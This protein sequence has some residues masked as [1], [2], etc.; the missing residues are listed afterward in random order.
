[1]T[2]ILSDYDLHLLAEGTH[3]RSFEVLGAHPRHNEEEEEAGTSF[4]VWAP[5]ARAVS[6]IGDFNGWDVDANP[7]SPRRD[8]GVWA[9]FVPGVHE[10]ERYKFSVLPWQGDTRYEKADPYAFYAELRPNSASIVWDIGGYRWHDT[11]WMATRGERQSLDAPIAVYEVHLGSWARVPD[12][13]NRWLTYSEIATRLARYVREMGYTHVELMPVAEHALDESWGYQ[14]L[15]YFAPTSRFGEPHQFMELVDTMHREGIGV[16]MDWVPGH[17]PKDAHG[18]G[19]FDGTHL[20]EH[21]DPRI[22]EHA[23]W[24][25]YVFNYSRREVANFLLSNA[26]FWLELYHIDG[27]RVDAVASMIYRDYSRN[28]GEWVPNQFGGREDLDAIAFLRRLN[29]TIYARH[30]DTMTIAEESTAWPM[31]SRPTSMGGLGFGYKWNMGWMHDSLRFMGEDPVHRQYHMHHV[32]FSMLYA[33]QENFVL[34]YSHDEVVHGKGSM[35]NKM[36]GDD[37]QKFA[38]LRALY[39]Y[40]YGHPGKK[41]LFMGLDFGQWAEWNALSSLEWHLLQHPPHRGLQRWVQRLNALY[42][43]S[44]ALY[45]RDYDDSGF[46]WIDATDAANAVISFVRHGADGQ[47]D[48]LVV[49]NLTPVPRQRYRLG[50]PSG[51]RWSVALNS[52][53]GQYGGSGYPAPAAYRAQAQPI[54]GRDHSIEVTL[55]PLATLFLV[56]GDAEAA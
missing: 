17:F 19:M 22:G 34:P 55:P 33:Y 30:P 5:N 56:P 40:M 27:I 4:A 6:V 9:A 24:G 16:I 42:A 32:T 20:Y 1:M 51:G 10:G 41:L 23:D 25:T 7:L 3:L 45:E 52:D 18:L 8:S 44:P 28:A 13:G 36:P 2:D 26:L 49:C 12:E 11:D 47:S 21:A 29:E 43:R 53:D 15:S 37:W 38:N 35:P 14:T 48:V 31:V 50:V 39:G 54:H 46:E